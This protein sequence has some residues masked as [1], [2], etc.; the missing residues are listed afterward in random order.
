MS[1]GEQVCRKLRSMHAHLTST[2]LPQQEARCG[3]AACRWRMWCMAPGGQILKTQW[4]ETMPELVCQALKQPLPE[5][6]RLTMVQVRPPHHAWLAQ[7]CLYKSWCLCGCPA[8]HMLHVQW[9]GSSAAPQDL[10]RIL[11]SDDDAAQAGLCFMTLILLQVWSQL[12]HVRASLL[13]KCACKHSR[14]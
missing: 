5:A 2:A 3:E 12:A 4:P 9:R 7:G 8:L 11:R 13:I 6:V 14:C 10:P 1:A